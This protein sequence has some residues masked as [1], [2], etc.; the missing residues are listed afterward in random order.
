VKVLFLEDDPGVALWARNAFA[1]LG[2][3]EDVEVVTDNFRLLYD[4]ARWEG[5]DVFVTD[6]M[7][8]NF[9][10]RDL[11]EWVRKRFPR[12]RTIVYTA[13]DPDYVDHGGFADKLIRKGGQFEDLFEAVRG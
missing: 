10:T 9:V 13:A 3:I 2:G 12:I 4:E 1:F 5:V 7:V 6:W 8:P 11:L